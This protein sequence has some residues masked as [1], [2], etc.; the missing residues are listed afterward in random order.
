MQAH[1]ASFA[2]E[3]RYYTLNTFGPETTDVW[4]VCH[5]Y[6]QLGEYFL[7]HFQHLPTTQHYCIVPQGLHKFYLKGFD[8]R[9][10]ASWMTRDDRQLD[11]A[12]IHSYLDSVWQR[13]SARWAQ[14]EQPPR[15]HMLG[16]SQG[17]A[18][19]CRWLAHAQVPYYQLI[20]WA[21]IFPPDIDRLELFRQRPH[22]FIVG[23]QDPF[24][25]EEHLE[26]HLMMLRKKGL[27]P[28]P[29]YFEGEHTLNPEILRELA[30]Q[31]L[32]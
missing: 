11:I 23:R 21:G 16:F 10:G 2:H 7:R 22:Y 15:F 29:R 4:F 20:V 17:V 18:T 25:K 8:G 5:G 27:N 1:L 26:K 28:Q 3:A 19:L 6:G 32:H 24:F 12:N 13:E 14:A 31:R 30:V 9:V